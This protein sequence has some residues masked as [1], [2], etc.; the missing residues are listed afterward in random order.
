MQGWFYVYVVGASKFSTTLDLLH[1]P[2]I[3]SRSQSGCALA[4]ACRPNQRLRF[5]M[6]L[7]C[8]PN[9]ERQAGGLSRVFG[10]KP[11]L[12]QLEDD[13]A[14]LHSSVHAATRSAGYLGLVVAPFCDVK[15]VE[16]P[17]ETEALIGATVSKERRVEGGTIRV[18]GL[19][20]N[21]LTPRPQVFGFIVPRRVD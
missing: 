4:I 19:R 1:M 3:G 9:G 6:C 8:L 17:P 21:A 18:R 20:S 7:Y 16:R 13:A 10:T 15:R 5:N 12:C 11:C 2:H 14:E